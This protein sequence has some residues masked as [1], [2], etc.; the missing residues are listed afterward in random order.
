[1]SLSETELNIT[2]CEGCHIKF[3]CTPKKRK[4]PFTKEHTNCFCKNCYTKLSEQNLDAL[5]Y[6]WYKV[7]KL[8]ENVKVALLL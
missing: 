7:D 4:C 3:I 8:P 6:C 2:E 5:N 1:M